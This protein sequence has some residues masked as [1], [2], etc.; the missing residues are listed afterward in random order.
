[1]S[2]D[3]LPRVSVIFPEQYEQ[4]A[5]ALGRAF[6]NDPPLK[7]VLPDVVEPQARA[8]H[9]TDMFRGTL[10]IQRR[11]GQ[12]VFGVLDGGRVVAAA[13]TEGAGH[14]STTAI[15]V[16]G[17]GEMPRMVRGLGWG[18]TIRAIQ[19]M[20][21]LMRNHP[22]EPH[23]YLNFL[24]VDPDFQRKHCGAALLAH[25]RDIA[26]ERTDLAGVYLET[27]TEDNVAY[28]AA[29]G[30]QVLGEIYPLGVKMWRMFQRKGG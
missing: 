15:A 7:A 19:L 23:L 20:Q 25:L 4:T 10:G 28:Y 2:L 12:P 11:T 24:G 5:I 22:P 1:M 3:G 29:K 18:G 13:L 21:V 30:Y 9:L 27:A 26:L 16:A 14:T 8:R 6:I 17:L